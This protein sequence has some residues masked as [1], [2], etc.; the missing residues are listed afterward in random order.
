MSVS[1]KFQ[2]VL[3]AAEPV[4]R[5]DLDQLRV[6]DQPFEILPGDQ[7]LAVQKGEDE[8][9]ITR[10]DVVLNFFDELKQKVGAAGKR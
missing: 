2:P 1:L 8:D 7:L 10:V 3:S 4:S 9:E 6:V 5:W